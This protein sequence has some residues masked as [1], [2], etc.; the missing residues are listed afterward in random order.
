MYLPPRGAAKRTVCDRGM[1]VAKAWETAGTGSFIGEPLAADLLRAAAYRK[2]HW[3]FQWKKK[4]EKLAGILIRR[5]GKRKLCT[6]SM[7]NDERVTVSSD[8]AMRRSGI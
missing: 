7:R 3:A 1:V 5:E 2:F 8:Q 6:L 4:G